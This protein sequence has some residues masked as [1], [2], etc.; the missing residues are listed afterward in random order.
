MIWLLVAGSVIILLGAI[1]L[2]VRHYSG[3]YGVSLGPAVGLAI[4]IV[5]VFLLRSLDVL[6]DTLTSG[7]LGALVFMFF[8][9]VVTGRSK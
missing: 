1:L 5:V 7:M 2:L 6:S 3:T 8:Y 4:G 9:A